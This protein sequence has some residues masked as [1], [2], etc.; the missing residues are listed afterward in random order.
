MELRA[1]GLEL[2]FA[3]RVEGEGAWSSIEVWGSVSETDVY[4][5][6]VCSF[7]AR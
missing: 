6:I 5:L 4:R 2:G 7:T 3:L 1:E